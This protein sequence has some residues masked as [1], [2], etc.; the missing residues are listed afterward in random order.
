M[1]VLMVHEAAAEKPST[2]LMKPVNRV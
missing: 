2:K 1:L